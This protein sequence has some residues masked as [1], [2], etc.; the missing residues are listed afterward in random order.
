M[1]DRMNRKYQMTS[2]WYAGSGG[3]SPAWENVSNLWDYLMKSKSTGPTATGLNNGAVYTKLFTG[4]SPQ[5]AIKPGN[6]LQF[7]NGGTG[8]Y[9]HSVIVYT[10]PSTS[11]D[12]NTELSKIT[13]A[14]NTID[15]IG[16]PL[17]DVITNKGGSNCNMRLIRPS[18]FK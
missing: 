17:W 15:N 9:T 1:R 2:E 3:G 11:S 4:S 12:M 14:Q 16:L 13:I 8:K 7:R 10:V 6:I 18:N 5:K